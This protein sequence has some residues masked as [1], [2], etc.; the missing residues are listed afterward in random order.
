MKTNREEA[1][2]YFDELTQGNSQNWIS[3]LNSRY[4]SSSAPMVRVFKLDK[5]RTN[6][7]EVYESDEFGRSRI[8]L[9]P[10][11]MRM[12]H[13]ED[14]WTQVVGQDT[15]PY[16]EVQENVNFVVNFKDM[17]DILRDHKDKKLS[18]LQISYKGSGVPTIEKANNILILKV[19]GHTKKEY[20]LED[21]KF[22]TTTQLS[23][24]INLLD[25][26]ECELK[27]ESDR[28]INLVDFDKTSFY[29]TKVSVFSK[30]KTHENSSDVIERGDLIL[31]NKWFLYE[32]LTNV[33]G[34]NMGWD[35]STMVLQSNLRSLDKANLPNN[36]KKLIERKQY[37]IKSKIKME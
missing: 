23:K 19:N 11:E 20:D 9:E 30:D 21:E 16:L 31:S 22:R 7:D 12:Y 34:G 24:K 8:Y 36:W 14:P 33:P 15:A 5:V 10:I 2:N 18:D 28:S 25:D 6:I 35:Y 13:L 4:I 26:F 37:G 1:F 32:V 17:V 3:Y 27:G 29:N